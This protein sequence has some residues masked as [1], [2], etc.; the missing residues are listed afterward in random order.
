MAAISSVGTAFILGA[1]D[2]LGTIT[3]ISMGGI[4]TAEID[5]T[6]L[7]ST[8]KTYIMGTL[9]GGT[10]TVSVDL[11]A[12]TLVSLP[13]AGD[14]TPTSFSIRFGTHAAS[15]NQKPLFSFSGY[16]QNTTVEAA[17][18]SQVKATYT[19]RVSGDMLVGPSVA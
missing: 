1:G 10:I 15:P 12:G 19:I 2:I 6:S 11:I 9:D 4:S 14:S 17:V 3:A 16:I 8:F 7:A 5:V 18:D 13:L